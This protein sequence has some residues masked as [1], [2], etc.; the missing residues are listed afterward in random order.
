M[1]RVIENWNT[2]LMGFFL[3]SKRVSTVRFGYTK[4]ISSRNFL[5]RGKNNEN[6]AVSV[7]AVIRISKLGISTKY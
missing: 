4:L 7:K 5:I 1:T 3:F 2:R 6:L